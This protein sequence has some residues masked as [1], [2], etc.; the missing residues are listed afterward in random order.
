MVDTAYALLA[1]V[2]RELGLP[3]SWRLGRL[4]VAAV[5]ALAGLPD[6]AT[7]VV[8]AVR[9]EGSTGAWLQYFE[10]NVRVRLGQHDSALNLLEGY[11]EAMPHRRSYIAHDWWWEPLRS[12]PRFR[13]L[14]AEEVSR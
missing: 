3:S 13:R 4:Q 8:E 1:Q 2:T 12:H 7:A 11:L 14:V 9:Q 5:L 6:S 10:A